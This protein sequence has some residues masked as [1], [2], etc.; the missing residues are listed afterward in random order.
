MLAKHGFM[1]ASVCLLPPQPQEEAGCSS[2]WA[3]MVLMSLASAGVSFALSWYIQELLRRQFL[4]TWQ[5]DATADGCAANLERCNSKGAAAGSEEAAGCTA[6]ARAG[7]AQADGVP[8]GDMCTSRAASLSLTEDG[9][10]PGADA[11]ATQHVR[12]AQSDACAVSVDSLTPEAAMAPPAVLLNRAPASAAAADSTA[13]ITTTAAITG[14]TNMTTTSTPSTINS[15]AATARDINAATPAPTAATTST[16][17]A[18]G[19]S[20]PARPR[21]R[22]F[23]YQP[24]STVR[25][26]LLCVK[27]RAGAAWLAAAA[28]EG[29]THMPPCAACCRLACWCGCYALVPVHQVSRSCVT[30]L[31]AASGSSAVL[32]V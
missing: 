19:S 15:M 24:P 26:V 20:S 6:A 25:K 2:Q 10:L 32:A 29:I 30:A 13:I 22:L 28:R 12:S 23:T 7:D 16:P 31:V 3:S 4:S 1:A 5:E 9:C 27:V 11:A 14:A 17:P 18:A 8:A 21:S